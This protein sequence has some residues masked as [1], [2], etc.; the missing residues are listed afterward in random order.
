MK[1]RNKHYLSSYTLSSWSNNYTIELCEQVI[2]DIHQLSDRVT[3]EK[4]KDFNE[5]NFIIKASD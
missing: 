2:N 5:E 3:E 1:K 4:K